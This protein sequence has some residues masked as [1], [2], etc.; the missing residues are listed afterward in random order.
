[1]LTCEKM[2]TGR[3]LDSGEGEAKMKAKVKTN[4]KT[5][6]LSVKTKKK[7]MKQIPQTELKKVYR[8][9]DDIVA[10]EI[11]G[12]LILIPLSAG[13]GNMENEIYAL[14]Q[15][16]KEIWQRI[17]GKNTVSGIIVD[18]EKIYA[19]STG[20]IRRDVLG[21]IDELARR[22]IILAAPSR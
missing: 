20:T 1:M 16:G 22:R 19:S 9:S 11:E 18:L 8:Q 17:N 14:D 6:H 4:K 2:Q 7:E 13:I 5:V 12:E 21:L 3:F 15:T 10:R